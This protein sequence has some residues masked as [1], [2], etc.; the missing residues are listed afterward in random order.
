MQYSY[1]FSGLTPDLCKFRVKQLSFDGSVTYSSVVDGT[2]EMPNAYRLEPIYPNPFNPTATIRFAVRDKQP[3]RLILYDMQGR[4]M[5]VMFE[6]EP[7]RAGASQ[8]VRIHG[9]TLASGV[10]L[11][12]MESASFIVSQKVILRS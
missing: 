10:Y 11:V 6:G 1:D 7:E 12:R 5:E 9:D 3:I 4:L 8:T 2:V